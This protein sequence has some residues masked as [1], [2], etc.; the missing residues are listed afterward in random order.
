MQEFPGAKVSMYQNKHK[1]A[2]PTYIKTNEVT[3]I[4]QY[5]INTYGVPRYTEAN[6]ALLSIV[7]FPFL[8][9]MMYGDIGHGSLWLILGII[10]TLQGKAWGRHLV[11]LMGL[12]SIYCGFV[13]N[14]W[15][16]IPLDIFGSC[17]NLN[18]PLSFATQYSNAPQTNKLTLKEGDD[19]SWYYP[20]LRASPDLNNAGVSNTCTYPFGQDPGW[21]LS[22]KN[23]LT[24]ANNIKMK[25][26]VIFGVFHMTLGIINK[27][28]NC[29]Y[30]SD[31]VTLFTEVITGIIILLSLF[32]FMDFVI[33]MKWF[34]QRD[35]DYPK[36]WT[37]PPNVTRKFQETD[38]NFKATGDTWKTENDYLNS[39]I[40]GIISVMIGA[41][42]NFLNCKEVDKTKL[43]L[44]T[45]TLPPKRSSCDTQKIG[46]Y[47]LICV[48][49]CVP[50]FMCVK[51]CMGL[52]SEHHD[53]EHNEVEMAQ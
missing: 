3:G 36:P 5:L 24:F 22:K 8:Y 51:P 21:A 53:E 43:D 13:Y 37:P 14:E 38:G 2:P 52:C 19:D 26:S 30:F 29:V 45:Q 16:G 44:L 12:C 28:Q 49:I 25:M 7:T 20:R 23:K 32:G 11:L 27:G 15:F 48:V 6:P 9:G 40:P 41:S 17:Y 42:I 31:Y 46:S 33:I 47:L 39:L 35:I 10:L 18:N 34:T 4:F 1:I 50:I